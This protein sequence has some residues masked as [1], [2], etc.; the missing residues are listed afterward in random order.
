MS[1]FKVLLISSPGADHRCPSL[2]TGNL[3]SFARKHGFK[4]EALHLHLHAAAILGIPRYEEIIS[5]PEINLCEALFASVL[6][7]NDSRRLLDFIRRHLPNPEKLSVQI[8]K[9]MTEIYRTIDWSGCDLVGFSTDYQ[10]VFSSILMASW[11][12]RDHPH[13]RI[14]IDGIS[15][16]GELGV[17]VLRAFPFIDWCFD[18]EDEEGFLILLDSLR[19][20]RHSFENNVP[21]MIYR[22]GDDIITNPRRVLEDLSGLPD[23]DYDDYFH[24]IETH[25]ALEG[26]E[27]FTYL[28]V[29]SSRGCR[30]RCSFCADGHY[31]AP[32]RNWPPKE[33]AESI[34]RLSS[35]HSIAS[36]LLTDQMID[37]DH[38][39]ELFS[40]IAATPRN[41][42]ISCDMRVGMPK[43]VLEAM[44]RAGVVEIQLG[45]EALDTKLLRKMRKG[46]RLVDNLQTMKLCEE[47]GIRTDVSNIILGFPSEDQGDVDRSTKAVG[48][49][50]AYMPPRRIINC[51]LYE[52]SPLHADPKRFGIKGV[53]EAGEIGKRLPKGIGDRLRLCIKNWSIRG[54]RPDYSRFRRAFEKW[55]R[56]YY[57]Q[58]GCGR[59]PLQYFD[60][61]EF[62]QIEDRRGNLRTIRLDGWMKDLYLFCDEAKSV[63]EIEGHF[64]GVD[65]TSIRRTLR[66]LCTEKFIF[67][68]DDVYLSLAVRSYPASR[69][70][71]PFI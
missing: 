6:Y 69:R 19:K 38:A 45:L 49:A 67:E 39:E 60:C 64:N 57:D 56:E 9:T 10:Q 18:G 28:P 24:L 14:F 59:R 58:I 23:P 32:L 55:R 22:C 48:Y 1:Q 8:E 2:H 34:R 44:R 33:V 36:I 66:F 52:G 11:I 16:A 3:S 5:K 54:V 21:G 7:G 17:S 62:I 71:L 65:K 20:R 70:N 12:R 61:G 27:T 41:F 42:K 35:R 53:D 43:R 37:P 63:N 40:Q 46:T 50:S 31:W 13:I 29:E 30:Y 25:P 4:A 68:E 26:V 51:I 15:V 47:L